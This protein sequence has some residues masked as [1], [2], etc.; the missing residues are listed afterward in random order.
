MN[1]CP[2]VSKWQVRMPH[3]GMSAFAI[4]PGKYLTYDFW[5]TQVPVTEH[6]YNNLHFYLTIVHLFMGASL[7]LCWQHPW[8]DSCWSHYSVLSHATMVQLHFSCYYSYN[9]NYNMGVSSKWKCP[10]DVLFKIQ[11][12]VKI[13]NLCTDIIIYHPINPSYF[14]SNGYLNKQLRLYQFT[15]QQ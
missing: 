3:Q 5:E 1:Q 13:F 7:R 9:S 15:R 6:I 14:Y 4:S 11:M 10:V 8:C 2:K 12:H